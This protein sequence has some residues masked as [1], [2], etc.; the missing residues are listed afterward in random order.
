MPGHP[1]VRVDDVVPAV[2][3]APADLLDLGHHAV[4]Q[5]GQLLLGN[6]V[7]R[8]GQ[9]VVDADAGVG[10]FDGGL[11][12]RGGTGEDF[13][14]HAGLGQGGG[15]FADVDVHPAGIA[16]TRLLHGRGVEGEQGDPADQCHGISFQHRRRVRAVSCAS[17]KTLLL[18][19]TRGL[20]AGAR[21]TAWRV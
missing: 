21:R 2:R 15:E 4:Q 13:H 6:L 11:V 8:A 5:A 3:L 18:P 10:M 1:V 9:D 12:G 16:G 7:R 20:P 17:D 19:L 14:F